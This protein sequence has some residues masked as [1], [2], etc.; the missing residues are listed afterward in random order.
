MSIPLRWQ[1]FGAASAALI[2]AAAVQAPLVRAQVPPQ[3]PAPAQPKPQPPAQLPGQ[4][5]RVSLTAGRSTVL[6]TDFEIVRIAVTNPAVADAIG[7]PAARDPRRRQGAGHGQPDRL[8]HRRSEALRPRRRAGRD[9]AAA[10]A[11]DPLSRRGHHGQRHATKRSSFRDRSRATSSSL[12]AAEIA[13]ASSAEDEADQHA[14]APGRP[15]EPAGHAAGAVRR[16]EP[17]RAHGARRQLRRVA[18]PITPAGRRRSNSRRPTSNDQRQS[19]A[20]SSAI[21]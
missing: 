9:D 10:A 13:Q 12:R 20:W 6:L 18:G 15:G 17:T 2:L 8:E 16:G 1:R 19:P 4:V 5:E 3:T 14:A 21:S 11:A 7:R